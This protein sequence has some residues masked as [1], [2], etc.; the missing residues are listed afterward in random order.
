MPAPRIE[1]PALI[2]WVAG[3]PVAAPEC[4]YVDIRDN[5]CSRTANI[6][7]VYVDESTDVQW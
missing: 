1:P 3:E 4:D 6:T 5:A 7:T 2:D